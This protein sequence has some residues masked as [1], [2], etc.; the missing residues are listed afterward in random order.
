MAPASTARTSGERNDNGQTGLSSISSHEAA[1]DSGKIQ[2]KASEPAGSAHE[3]KGIRFVLLLACLFL[4]N[5]F[6]GYDSSCIGTLTPLITD[7]F[8][9]LNE[10][11]WYQT[12]Y[13]LTLLR[14]LY[15]AAFTIFSI[16]STLTA[17]APSSTLFIIGRALSGLGAAG[18]DSGVSIIIA[19][20]TSLERRPMFSGISGGL[21]CT[22]LAFGPLVSGAKANSTTW[23]I[24]FYILIPI[25]VAIIVM[26]YFSIGHLRQPDHSGLGNKETLALIDWVGLVI[27][28]LM[29]TCLVLGLQWAG[30]VYPWSDWRII[31]L[32]TITGVMLVCFLLVEH[33]AGDNA[34]VSLKMLRQRTVAFASLTAFCNFSALWAISFYL[35]LYFQAVRGASA[36]SS[37]LMYLPLAL[38]MSIAALLGGPITTYIGYYSPVLMLGGALSMIGTGLMTTFRPDS[39]AGKWISYQIIYGLGIGLSFQPPF[40]AVQNV[41]QGPAV[42]AALIFLNS[43]QILGGI[44]VLSVAQNVFL[45]RLVSY[46]DTV[47]PHLDRS[48]ILN[49]GA[50][51]LVDSVSGA[52]R[53]Q[54]LAAYNKALVDIFYIAWGFA[55]WLLSA[56]LA[57]SSSVL[58]QKDSNQTDE[59]DTAMAGWLKITVKL[60]I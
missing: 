32:L 57:S 26:I 59:S 34:M 47:L 51:G 40:L 4:G 49:N 43:V 23:R 2:P 12:A 52:H 33:R 16:G 35:P 54:V 3:L 17:A 38:T 5:F 39:P 50:V 58:I 6:V 60:S 14:T 9:A 46:L 19:N 41:L 29:T 42:S 37:G 48:T 27:E 30:M 22:A 36:L 20:T 45:T 13:L 55:V 24:S 53:G 7:Q 1:R 15:M 11:G 8:H 28:L 31:L 25:G 44:I 56:P 18:I 10:L 21:E